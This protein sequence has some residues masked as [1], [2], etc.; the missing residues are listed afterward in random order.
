MKITFTL[1]DS[2]ADSTSIYARIHY[3]GVELKFGTSETIN[4]KYWD[5]KNK[6][7]K[8]TLKEHPEFNARLERIETSI[9]NIYRRYLND[10]KNESP[11]ASELKELLDKEIRNK[12]SNPDLKKNFFEFFQSLIDGSIDGKRTHSTNAKKYSPN[13]I[14]VYKNVLSRLKQYKES[15][16]IQIDFKNID[17]EFHADYSYYLSKDRLLSANTIGRDIKTIKTVVN[18]ALELGIVVNPQIKSKK[19][20]VSKE[21]TENIYLSESE[22]K[23]IEDLD[24]SNNQ[25]LDNVRDLFLIGAFTGLRFSDWTQI[26]SDKINNGF[27][28]ITQN[29]TSDSVVIPLHPVVNRILNKYDGV[30][31]KLITNQKFNDYLKEISVLIPS[32]H[33]PFEYSRT[34]GGTKVFFTEEKW[35]KVSTHTARRS[36]ATNEFLAETPTF[37]IMGITGHRTEKSFYKY[38]KLTPRD[39]AKIQKLHWSKRYSTLQAV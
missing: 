5:N 33:K 12:I 23:E 11:T 31:P 37:I 6:V 17:L 7:V 28:E 18:E 21:D 3:N 19:F 10:N 32:L 14:K 1:R 34:Q 26:T 8:R 15:K 9:K 36:F 25:R 2:S 29:K 24:L 13:T 35:M 39:K 30:L 38:I 20:N 22:L 27:I 16:K 4:P